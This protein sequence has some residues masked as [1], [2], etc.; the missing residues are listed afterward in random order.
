VNAGDAGQ[1]TACLLPSPLPR[2][3]SS[4]SLPS[5]SS[6]SDRFC[7]NSW[8]ALCTC[9]LIVVAS[10]FGS[11]VLVELVVAPFAAADVLEDATAALEALATANWPA[12]KI[13]ALVIVCTA[14]TIPGV[15]IVSDAHT[16]GGAVPNA[17][18]NEYLCAFGGVIV[19]AARK[20][21]VLLLAAGGVA[22]AAPK[23]NGALFGVPGDADE[24]AAAGVTGTTDRTAVGGVD[25]TAAAGSWALIGEVAAALVVDKAAVVALGA[26]SIG[27]VVAVVALVV[28]VVTGT[29]C[30]PIVLVAAAAIGVVLAAVT[31]VAALA[32]S[33][34]SARCFCTRRTDATTA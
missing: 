17:N 27:V 25:G 14:V 13:V 7:S 9:S 19:E 10:A 2:L 24:F 22:A 5:L 12:T 8:R 1:F 11:D 34:L 6:G 18:A 16:A 15:V 30:T 23:R 3:L 21:G 29:L 28:A 33:A 26:D 20:Q 31:L 32:A 4:E